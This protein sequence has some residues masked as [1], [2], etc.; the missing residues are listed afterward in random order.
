MYVPMKKD[1]VKHGHIDVYLQRDEHSSQAY[2]FPGFDDYHNHYNVPI[3][4]SVSLSLLWSYYQQMKWPML[5]PFCLPPP[6]LSTLILAPI[7]L[8]V[9]PTATLLKSSTTCC[10]SWN[11]F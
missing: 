3:Y 2:D 7:F 6:P 8:G 1:I 5:L 11:T 10:N 4:W 9:G